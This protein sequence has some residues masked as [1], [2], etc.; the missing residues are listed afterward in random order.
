MGYNASEVEDL[1]EYAEA[2]DSV[3][4]CGNIIIFAD[5]HPSLTAIASSLYHESGHLTSLFCK[6]D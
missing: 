2:R 5:R 6:P 1:V 3:A 4:I